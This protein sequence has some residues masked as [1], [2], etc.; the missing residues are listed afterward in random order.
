MTAQDCPYSDDDVR[1][2]TCQPKPVDED[3]DTG[4]S[5]YSL[6]VHEAGHA[7]GLS[8]FSILDVWQKRQR[9]E[10]AHP[11][12]PD[13]VLNYDYEVP[14]NFDNNGDRREEADC[15]PHPFDIMAIYAL[16]QTVDR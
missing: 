2:N 13:V 10:M 11:T 8:G 14:A 9:Y 7:L 3:P 15:S 1:F 5:N 12:I 16:Y 6:I 4:F